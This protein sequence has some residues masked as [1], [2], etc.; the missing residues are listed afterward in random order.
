MSRVGLAAPRTYA[1]MSIL[2]NPGTLCGY[3]GSAEVLSPQYCHRAMSSS[4]QVYNPFVTIF[5]VW[6]GFQTRSQPMWLV[7]PRSRIAPR[8]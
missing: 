5:A 1:L 3:P 7:M 8:P 2:A 6:L 4:G